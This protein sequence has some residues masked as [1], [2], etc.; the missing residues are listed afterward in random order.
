MSLRA[1]LVLDSGVDH[2]LR[3]GRVRPRCR[4]G[5]APVAHVQWIDNR[6]PHVTVDAAARIPTRVGLAGVV[7]PHGDHVFPRHEVPRDVVRKADI[8][9]GPPAQIEAVDPDIAV[10]VDA[11]ELEPRFPLACAGREPEDPAVPA[12]SRREVAT[13]PAGR[14]VL[15]R[16]PLDAPIVR[17]VQR[18]PLPVVE[19][20]LVSTGWIARGEAPAW[21]HRQALPL[22]AGRSHEH[23]A[24]EE[25]DH[26]GAAGPPPLPPPPGHGLT[27]AMP[28]RSSLTRSIRAAA[29]RSDAPP[30]RR[31]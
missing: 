8:A 23:E 4:H 15:P 18:T 10:H 5:D 21:I 31:A 13:A 22:R 29:S 12:D 26:Q 28:S 6:E 7:Y 1:S 20:G 14:G 19:A 30:M 11:V 2:D 16:R 27:T 3:A 24:G 17:Q 25:D 9:V